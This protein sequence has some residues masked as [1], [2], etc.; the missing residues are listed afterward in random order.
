V[1]VAL[2]V[3]AM[4]LP[5]K[6]DHCQ[7]SACVERVAAGRCSQVHVTSCI[8]RAALRWHVSYTML[9][10]K[11]WC[12][13][14]FDPYAVNGPHAGLFQ[15]N[16]STWATTPYAGRSPWRAKWNA[17]AAA[18]MHHAGRGGEWACR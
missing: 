4:V 1:T 5:A 17:L 15:F 8:H 12:E 9:R 10:R 16:W 6:G 14:R 2:T 7:T 3:L 13:S 18:W 11:A